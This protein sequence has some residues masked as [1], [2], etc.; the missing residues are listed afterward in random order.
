[1]TSL[2]RKLSIRLLAVL[3]GVLP[4]LTTFVPIIS[5]AELGNL[6]AIIAHIVDKKLVNKQLIDKQLVN[7]KIY[8]K[9]LVDKQLAK[10]NFPTNILST[11]S[12][13]KKGC[14]QTTF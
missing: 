13:S 8:D 9:Q 1:M 2:N 5:I 4:L 7:I 6:F 12:L 11:N 10:K 14:R 3:L